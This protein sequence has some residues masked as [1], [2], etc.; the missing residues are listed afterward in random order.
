MGKMKRRTMVIVLYYCLIALGA[1][2]ASFTIAWYASSTNL[3][4]DTILIQLDTER[5]L[6]ISLSEDPETFV[7]VIH[8]NE[9]KGVGVYS[10][11]SSNFNGNWLKEGATE[12]TLYDLSYYLTDINGTPYLKPAK[13][14]Y[15][16]QDF[17]LMCD[18]DVYVGLDAKQTY[19]NPSLDRNREY[20]ATLEGRNED[21]SNRTAEEYLT[22]LND[23][24]NSTRMGFL[25]DDNFTVIDPYHSEDVLFGGVL[26]NTNDHYF[27]Y[28]QNPVDRHSYETFYG[29]CLDRSK[30][31]YDDPLPEDSEPLPSYN[32][33]AARHKAGVYRLNIDKSQENGAG[34]PYE[35]ATPLFTLD[36]D[37]YEENLHTM[38]PSFCFE[39]KAY[40]PKKINLSFFLEGWDIDSVNSSAGG[41]FDVNISFRIVRER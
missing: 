22:M 26:D 4:V 2:S 41:S 10:P 7:D 18:D 11:V 25:L 9:V 33:F 13:Y 6:K 36:E 35:G 40:T 31:V 19:V 34:I 16:N 5:D 12:P 29:E 20:A 32:A 39:L 14:G 8:S 21:N 24:V 30:L 38:F 15:F 27:D 37:Y 3:R 23:V 28:Y 17:Y 1:M